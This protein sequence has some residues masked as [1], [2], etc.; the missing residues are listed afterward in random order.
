MSQD[1]RRRMFEEMSKHNIRKLSRDLEAQEEFD[2]I[3]L[4]DFAP[5]QAFFNQR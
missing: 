2:F 5:E 3:T 4:F 1:E